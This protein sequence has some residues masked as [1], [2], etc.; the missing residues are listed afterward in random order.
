MVDPDHVI[1]NPLGLL[2]KCSEGK[3]HEKNADELF[4][5]HKPILNG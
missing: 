2:R 4:W 5:S 3:G 1:I